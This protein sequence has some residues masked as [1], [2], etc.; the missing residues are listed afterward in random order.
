M[1]EEGFTKL[2]ETVFRKIYNQKCE[3]EEEKIQPGDVTFSIG[4]EAIKGSCRN[5]IEY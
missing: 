5:D 3:N 4:K 1:L 2:Y